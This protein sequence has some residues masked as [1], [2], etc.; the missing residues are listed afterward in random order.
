MIILCVTI[1][2]GMGM[3]PISYLF[4]NKLYV[5]YVD[6]LK[7]KYLHSSYIKINLDIRRSLCIYSLNNEF[8]ILCSIIELTIVSVIFLN[9]LQLDFFFNII[10]YII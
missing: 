9:N 8:N 4:N 7:I 6:E 2:N 1:D 3:C 5:M 10:L